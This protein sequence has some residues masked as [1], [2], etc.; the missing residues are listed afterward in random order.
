MTPIT[1]LQGDATNPSTPGQK[2]IAHCCNNIGQWGAGF[3]G[4]LSGRYPEA[5]RLYRQWYRGD[6]RK[7]F[8]LGEV[9]LVKLRPDLWAANIIGQVGV[10]SPGNPT[11]VRYDALRRGLHS[12]GTEA[13]LLHASVHLPRLGCGLAG[14][15]WRQVERI[16]TEELSSHDVSVTVYDLTL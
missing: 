5:E 2:I 1:Y 7:L 6:L 12:V 16:I 10:R 9:Q 15:D 3:S 4:A 8:R 14:G 13:G 11:P